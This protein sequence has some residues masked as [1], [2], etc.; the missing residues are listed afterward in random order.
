MCFERLIRFVD[1]GGYIL[2]GN[3]EKALPSEQVIGQKVQVV[4]GSL[5]DGFNKID[6]TAVVKK[7]GYS[8]SMIEV[9]NADSDGRLFSFCVR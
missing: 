9:V 3:L 7:A 5:E 8:Q 2:F 4:A 1:D 6:Q